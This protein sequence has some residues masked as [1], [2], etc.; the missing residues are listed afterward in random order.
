MSNA[1]DTAT[2]TAT[3]ATTEM[4]TF[5]VG[6]LLLGL[7]ICQV[8]EINRHLEV[9]SVPHA[10]KTVRGVVNLRGDVATVFDLSRILGRG[11][12][13]IGEN[14]RNVVLQSDEHINGLLVDR[15]ADILKVP[16]G[17]IIPAPA[18]IE[19]VE[20]RFFKGV[21]PLDHELVIVLDLDEILS[22]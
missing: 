2:T 20:G 4:V 17:R 19:G 21:Y 18:N 11:V 14:S 16:D 12:A 5:Y 8:R 6:D 15:V 7:P 22:T 3:T 1:I 9:T 13:V 10:P